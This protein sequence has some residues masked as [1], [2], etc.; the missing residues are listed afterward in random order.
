MNRV[1]SLLLLLVVSFPAESQTA[2]AFWGE[3]FKLKVRDAD[4]HVAWAD[5]TGTYFI[6][7]HLVLTGYFIIGS[8]SRESAGLVKLDKGLTEVY[9]KGF[10]KEL[11]KKKYQDI[12]FNKKKMYLLASD[13][14]K[15]SRTLSLQVLELN[16]ADAAAVGDW[17]EIALFNLDSKR[18]DFKF[19]CTL[20]EDS[21][22][23][24]I[25]TA[26]DGDKSTRYTVQEF[27]EDF[28]PAF[29]QV[30]IVHEMEPEKIELEEILTTPNGNILFVA[31]QMDYEE[32]KKE[33]KK[34]L[35]F[36]NYNLRLYNNKGEF[37]K[38]VNPEVEGRWLVNSKSVV[39]KNGDI[40]VAAFY[41]NTKKAREINGLMMVRI[42]SADGS[43][44]NYTNQEISASQFT[45]EYEEDDE[46]DED[47]SKAE[48]AERKRFEKLSKDEDGINRSYKIRALTPTTDGGMAFVAE[49]FYTYTV[50]RYSSTTKSYTTYIFYI[51]EDL[52]VSKFDQS[53]KIAWMKLLPKKQQ[54][55][56]SSNYDVSPNNYFVS[57]FQ[58][59]H[60]GGVSVISI[61]G[62]NTFSILMND[63]P[64]NADV[65]RAGQ[66]AKAML[67]AKKSHAFLLNVDLAS[68]EIKRKFIFDNQDSPPAMLR[69]G[70]LMGNIFYMVGKKT[71]TLGILSKPKIAVG[72]LTFK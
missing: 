9:R 64:R 44:L 22:R 70:V 35:Q 25:V 4:L 27:K 36:Q 32:G 33:K 39:L 18:D 14:D 13:F 7:E 5:N 46:D 69:H 40:G 6:E 11:R 51:S 62:K 55:Q 61:P 53:G 10:D 57:R 8:T 15:S 65:T 17:K 54:E 45:N 72:K 23:F 66:K 3:E 16:K 68:G 19:K 59:P 21:A 47:E 12:L 26:L 49:K 28:S 67:N 2:S 42:N 52:I 24:R 20:T 37:I 1:L 60:W 41:S 30:E 50:R 48:R 34:N 29:K 38:E 63:N 31:R 56:V 58:F 43:V 71:G